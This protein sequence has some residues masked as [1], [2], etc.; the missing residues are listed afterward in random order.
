MLF[1]IHTASASGTD[2]PIYVD[3][4]Q[5][6]TEAIVLKISPEGAEGKET[7]IE[8]YYT[9]VSPE[10]KSGQVFVPLRV[11]CN[12][13]G[14]EIDWQE[15]SKTVSISYGGASATLT[16]GSRAAL[17][18]GSEIALDFTPYIKKGRTMVSLGFICEAFSCGSDNSDGIVNLVSEPFFLDG[19]RVASVQEKSDL[20]IEWTLRES[21]TTLCARR[22]YQFMLDSCVNEIPAPDYYGR[23]NVND[24][25]TFYQRGQQL[26]FMEA[27]GFGGVDEY[28]AAT[29]GT[30]ETAAIRHY[31]VYN[32]VDD[33]PDPLGLMPQHGTDYGKMIVHDFTHDIWYSVSPNTNDQYLVLFLIGD[34][35]T[36]YEG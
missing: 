6:P 22:L 17:K 29:P 34:W 24:A 32:R 7:L 30:G 36:I 3:G 14:A 4:K 21:Q 10:V 2:I 28:Y 25:N 35:Q 20:F 8:F 31:D 9:D 18:D 27:E 13:W 5:I 23:W 1:S 12:Y 33:F 15:K 19:K 26:Y 11:I 16:I